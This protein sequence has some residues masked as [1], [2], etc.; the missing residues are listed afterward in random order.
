MSADAAIVTD[1]DMKDLYAKLKEKEKLEDEKEK[2]KWK[3]ISLKVV[4][5]VDKE[6]FETLK[7]PLK[8]DNLP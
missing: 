2:E 1:V 7:K 4:L 6:D 3:Y 8:V 5:M